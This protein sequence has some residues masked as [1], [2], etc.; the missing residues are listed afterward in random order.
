VG[1]MLDAFR[2]GLGTEA[3]LLRVCKVGKEDFEKGYRAHLQEV[4]KSLRS[5]PAEKVLTLTQLQEAYEK[6]PDD[7]DAAARLAEQYL[8]RGRNS[9]ARKL[10]EAVLAK[11]KNHP[12]ASYVKARLLLAAGDEDAA[13]TILEAALKE[14]AEPKVLQALGRIYFEKK[15]F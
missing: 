8:V 12:L 2:D 14:T 4:I 11:K 15:D 3:A 9:E 10:V 1:E 6:N 7:A 5:K 13:R